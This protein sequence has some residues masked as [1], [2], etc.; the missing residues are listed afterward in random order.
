MNYSRRDAVW[1]LLAGFPVSLFF[2]KIE[3]RPI[4]PSNASDYVIVDG[5]ILHRDDVKRA[6][7]DAA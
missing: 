7:S 3:I 6:L 4:K 1:F 2:W 5:W